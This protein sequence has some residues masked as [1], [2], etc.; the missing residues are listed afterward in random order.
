QYHDEETGLHYNRHRYYDPDSGR[1]LTQDPIGLAG[2]VN[3]Y[4]YVG[5][6]PV[7]HFDPL[8]L[9]PDSDKN[10]TDR[11]NQGQCNMLLQDIER[12]KKTIGNI[13]RVVADWHPGIKLSDYGLGI[14][15]T[16]EGYR[17]KQYENS[18]E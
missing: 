17:G 1:Y 10:P 13:E 5:G 18:S 3:V 14:D 11:I 12:E 6:N 4:G 15:A 16:P 8:G 7:S 9:N 2:G